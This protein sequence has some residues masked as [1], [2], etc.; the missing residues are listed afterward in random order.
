MVFTTV[1]FKIAIKLEPNSLITNQKLGDAYVR[2][3]MFSEAVAQYKRVK[4]LN[5]DSPLSYLGLGIV[6]ARMFDIDKAI[7]FFKKGIYLI[8]HILYPEYFPEEQ[9]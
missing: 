6:H 7:S 3:G 4:E 8:G 9:R 5:P 2:K 1:V